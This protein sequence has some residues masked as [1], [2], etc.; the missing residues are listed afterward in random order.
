MSCPSC[1][2]L[3]AGPRVRPAPCASTGELPGLTPFTSLVAMS[4]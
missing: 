1:R 2:G 4:H 3:A